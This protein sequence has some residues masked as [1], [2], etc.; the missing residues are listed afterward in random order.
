[1]SFIRESQASIN[2]SSMLS[3]LL[4]IA[5]SRV[6]VGSQGGVLAF[7]DPNDRHELLRPFVGEW[8]APSKFWLAADVGPL[9]SPGKAMRAM[10]LG[11]RFLYE[12]YEGH[13]LG[14]IYR[15]MSITGYDNYLQKY[16]ATWVDNINTSIMVTAGQVDSS[17]KVFTFWGQHNDPLGGTASKSRSVLQLIDAD[18]Y[19]IEMFLTPP[20]GEEFK[21]LELDYTRP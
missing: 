2:T 18:H 13:V 17:G 21:A 6:Q 16:T 7:T 14:Q 1:M 12:E 8:N 9:C 5:Q 15:G 11:G 10:I 4:G 3:N 20:D 19:M